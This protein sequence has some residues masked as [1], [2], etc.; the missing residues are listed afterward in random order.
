MGA[1][2]VLSRLPGEL[3]A[4]IGLTGARLD[5]ADL[6]YTVL[7]THYVPS[8]ALPELA[9]ALASCADSSDVLSHL[10]RLAHGSGVQPDECSLA[11]SRDTIDA[12][13]ASD[14]VEEILDR[15]E[16]L[17][18]GHDF[19]AA[20]RATLLRM[21]PT[22]LKVTLRLL[23]EARQDDAGGLGECLKR[24]FRAMQRCVAPPADFFEGI[25]AALVDKDKSPKWAPS[26]VSDVSDAAVDEYFVELGEREL[27]SHRLPGFDD[28]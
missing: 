7:A 12:V 1:T 25:R 17:G 11:R 3:G 18:S 4:Y 22:S 20:T 15:L 28:V 2:Y 10:D 19:A 6:L 21:S 16:A 24:E 8:A 27:S 5:A 13:F 26:A 23:R 9:A 14:R